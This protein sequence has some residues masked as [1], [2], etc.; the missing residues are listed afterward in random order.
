MG[1]Y[2]VDRAFVVSGLGGREYSSAVI[3]DTVHEGA[4]SMNA[5]YGL[6]YILV[7]FESASTCK[8]TITTCLQ[9][10]KATLLQVQAL[11]CCILHVIACR[12]IRSARKYVGSCE[13]L[14]LR[15]SIEIFRW[16]RQGT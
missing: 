6:L 11:L 1:Q 9:A 5:S 3:T 10:P 14:G 4:L 13:L 2:R 16:K 7:D 15:E 12:H 8:A